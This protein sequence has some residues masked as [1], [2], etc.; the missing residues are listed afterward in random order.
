M[1]S[2]HK[3]YSVGIITSSRKTSQIKITKIVCSFTCIIALLYSAYFG[4]VLKET[5][6][7][8]MNLFFVL[9][10]S[11]SLVLVK[12]QKYR[13]AKLWFFAVLITHVFILTTYI[14][15]PNTGFHFYYLLLPSGVFLLLD[16]DEKLAKI[17]IMI[18]GCWL[19]FVCENYEGQ[20]LVY[21]SKQAEYWIFSSTVIVIM[22]EIYFVM[23]MF[24]S[25]IN[26]HEQELKKIAS[27]DPLTG[28]DNRRTFMTVG[29]EMHA[30]A[31]RYQKCFSVI[32]MDIDFFKK[33]NDNYGHLAGDETLKKIA[34][35]LKNQLRKSDVLARYGGEEFILLLPDTDIQAALELAEVIRKSV[36]QLTI[37][38]EKHQ[39]TCTLSLGI[40]DYRFDDISLTDIVGQADQALYQAKE[41]GRNRVVAFK[42]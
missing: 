40:A 16:D 1:D 42:L 30:Y 8:L 3:D 5:L 32:L 33:I 26:L 19:F 28:I 12:Y 7:S 35:V 13:Y 38:I 17:T 27:I 4:F 11:I 22:V 6:I 24:S 41:Q 10:Y 21:L 31:V 20:P 29:D 18:L 34:C 9:A 25:A 39:I 2:L 14:F 37:E 15:T 36:E 23:S